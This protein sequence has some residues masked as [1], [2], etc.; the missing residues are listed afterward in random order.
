MINLLRNRRIA[1]AGGKAAYVRAAK[2]TRDHECHW[3]GCTKQVKPAM[4]GC[5]PHWFSLP[6]EIR[7]AIWRTFKA[8][9]EKTMTP[10][11]EYI[12]AAEAAQKWIRES[13]K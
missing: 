4:W 12:A 8:G 11:A 5:A 3:P 2:Q 9:Q 6:V 13:A 7:N 10:S 1:R